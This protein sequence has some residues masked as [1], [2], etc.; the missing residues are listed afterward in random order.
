MMKRDSVLLIIDMQNDFCPGGALEV[1]EGDRIITTINRIS[2]YFQRVVAT[3]DWHPYDHVSLARNQSSH[4]VGETVKINDID[5]YLWPDHCIQGSEGAE[6]H[7]DLDTSPVHLILRKGFRTELD[8]Y[9]AFFENDKETTTGLH[10]YL[11]SMNIDNVYITGLALDYCVYYSALDAVELGYNVYVI[12][13]A[14]KGIDEPK[15]N[16]KKALSNMQSKGVHL[17]QSESLPLE[18]LSPEDRDYG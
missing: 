7:P 11:Q 13:D 15:D 8:S 9:S 6:L 1:P 12:Q 14:S 10:S 17:V 16:L 3:Q 5:Q 18:G 2:P 4:D